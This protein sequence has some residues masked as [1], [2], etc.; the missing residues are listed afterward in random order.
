M[1]MNSDCVVQAPSRQVA[2]APS[3]RAAAAGSRQLA[4]IGLGAVVRERGRTGL[5]VE[6]GL[7]SGIWSGGGSTAAGYLSGPEGYLQPDQVTVSPAQASPIQASV[8]MKSTVQ[9]STD[10]H[11]SIQVTRLVP[12]FRGGVGPYPG[13]EPGPA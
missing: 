2:L 1:L 8:V 6:A 5:A 13:R 3:C 9:N 11:N 4:G 12:A 10:Q 7:K